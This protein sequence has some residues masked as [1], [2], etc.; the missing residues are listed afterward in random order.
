MGTH[1]TGRWCCDDDAVCHIEAPGDMMRVVLV[2][3][4]SGSESVVVGDRL[5][6]MVVSPLQ[7]VEHGAQRTEV[8]NAASANVLRFTTAPPTYR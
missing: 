8:D 3:V 1:V 5:L 7:A 6:Q 4:R 2:V